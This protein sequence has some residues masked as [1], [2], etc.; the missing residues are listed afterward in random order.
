MHFPGLQALAPP[1]QLVPGCEVP[2]QACVRAKAYD[3]MVEAFQ[4]HHELGLGNPSLRLYSCCLVELLR[5]DRLED[6]VRYR[7]SVAA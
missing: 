7:S 4:R 1:Q 2:L 6:A 3:T 5:A